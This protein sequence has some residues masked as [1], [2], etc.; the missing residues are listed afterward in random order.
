MSY[1]ISNNGKVCLAVLCCAL[2]FLVLSASDS[3]AQT[4]RFSNHRKVEIPEYAVI[5]LGPFGSGIAVSQSVGYRYVKSS[6]A[7]TDFVFLNRMGNVKDDG[8]DF[9]LITTLNTRNYLFITEYSDLDLSVNITYEHYPMDTQDDEFNINIAEEGLAANLSTELN[10]SPFLKISLYDKAG[11]WTE[12]IDTR[13]V[14]DEFGGR[15]FKRFDNSAGMD[16][17]WLL[18]DDENL[19]ISASRNDLVPS[20]EEFEDQEKISY[21]ESVALEKMFALYFMGG[22]RGSF[23]QNSFA[24][25][26]RANSSMQRYEMFGT[27]KLT[28]NTDSSMML[29]YSSGTES[30]LADMEGNDIDG[31]VG[32]ISFNSNLSDG[33]SQSIAYSR[34]QKTGFN[35]AFETCD[36]ASYQLGYETDIFTWKL[37]SEMN[38][39][40]PE[41]EYVSKYSDWRSGAEASFALTLSTKLL[42]SSSYSTRDNDEGTLS[43]EEDAD[44]TDVEMEEWDNDYST[45]NSSIGLSCAVFED[46]DFTAQFQ[47]VDRDSDSDSL[48]YSRDVVTA[49]FTYTHQF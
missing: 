45:W 5:E 32:A 2:L 26:D 46:L 27:V 16:M 42:L 40:D 14:S 43:I 30:S 35:S 22:L 24:V 17:D 12:Y 28:E 1:Y 4:L 7:G 33:L 9:P 48:S 34:G 3:F 10:P 6:G 18:K 20:D 39:V 36:T 8:S 37:F 49:A 21:S 38:S 25:D 13:G 19:A 29:G 47:H 23:E 31:I 41:R 44:Y 11:Y 15:K